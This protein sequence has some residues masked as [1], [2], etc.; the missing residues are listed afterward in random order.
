MTQ[1]L[2]ISWRDPEK[3][4]I[5]TVAKI[6]KNGGLVAFPTETVYGLGANALD[7]RAVKKI[8]EAK[9]RPADNPLIVH[10]ADKKE[11]HRLA[12][13][14]PG[15]AEKLIDK[16]WPGPLTL[17]LKKSKVVPKLTT[18]GLDTVAIRMPAHKIALALIKEAQV[19]I[20]APSANLFGKPSPTSAEHVIQDLDGKIDVI[21]DGGEAKIGVESTVLDLTANPPILLRPGAISLEELRDVLDEVEIHPIVKGKRIKKIA[22]KSPGMKYK[23]YA[24]NARVIVVEGNRQNVKNKI[25][26]LADKYKKEGKKVAVMTNDKNHGYKPDIVKFVGSDVDTIAKN[27]FKTFRD[28]DKENVDIIIAEGVEERGLGLAVMNRLRKSSFKSI[29]V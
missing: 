25:Q 2:K 21:I 23:H 12:K 4:K 22:A 6:I 5:E 7:T 15:E 26:Q 1:I 27:L 24:P 17:I 10:I 28:F 3:S 8:F 9:G 29:K 18:G 13:E 20:A 19:P 11:I 14:I 16:F